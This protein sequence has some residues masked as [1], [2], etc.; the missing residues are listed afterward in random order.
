MGPTLATHA[1]TRSLANPRVTNNLA[2]FSGSQSQAP[3]VSRSSLSLS[4]RVMRERKEIKDVVARRRSP[5]PRSRSLVILLTTS[6]LDQGCGARCRATIVSISFLFLSSLERG[7]TA[8]WWCPI[9]V[10]TA[11]LLP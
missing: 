2:R 6:D 1:P 3:I 9:R 11:P 7:M 4:I 10:F 8:R 5:Q